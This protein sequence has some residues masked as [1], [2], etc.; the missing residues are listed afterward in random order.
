MKPQS[1]SAHFSDLFPIIEKAVQNGDSFSFCSYGNSMKPFIP[2]GT[3]IIT[4]SPIVSELKKNDVVFYRRRSGAFVLHRIIKA[5]KD[6]SFTLCG[7]NQGFLEKGIQRDQIIARLSAMETDGKK[8]P[9]HSLS[10]RIHCAL[11]PARRLLIRLYARARK[12][13]KK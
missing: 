3:H 7:D 5:E 2:N 9:L 13:L 12:I 10:E 8:I 1:K 6:G 4:L 11:L